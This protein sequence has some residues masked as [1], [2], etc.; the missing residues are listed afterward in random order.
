MQITIEK[1]HANIYVTGKYE[2]Q[3]LSR[4]HKSKSK[5]D[6]RR[7]ILWACRMLNADL[8]IISSKMKV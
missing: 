7:K 3:Q 6:E 4:P 5:I 1:Q 2:R 8:K